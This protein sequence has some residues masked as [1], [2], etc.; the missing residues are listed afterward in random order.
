MPASSQVK[1]TGKT[2]FVLRYRSVN[3]SS[4][5][6]MDEGKDEDK[7]SFAEQSSMPCH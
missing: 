2:P 4:L 3:N 1:T 7:S 6:E 5:E